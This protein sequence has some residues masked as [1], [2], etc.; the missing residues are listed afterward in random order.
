V[1]TTVILRYTAALASVVH[2]STP[3]DVPLFHRLQAH[4]REIAPRLINAFP[5]T[6]EIYVGGSFSHE[7]FAHALKKRGIENWPRT[8]TGNLPAPSSSTIRA[9]SD[10]RDS[11]W[12]MRVRQGRSGSQRTAA[13]QRRLES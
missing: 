8:P 6:R 13:T 3:I 9:A 4:W 12:E 11:N 2:R 5:V 10:W 7:R 1:Q